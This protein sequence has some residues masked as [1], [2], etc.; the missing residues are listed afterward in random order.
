M[1]SNYSRLFICVVGESVLN[2]NTIGCSNPSQ[3]TM[4]NDYSNSNR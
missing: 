2:V 3:Y 4:C 1:E